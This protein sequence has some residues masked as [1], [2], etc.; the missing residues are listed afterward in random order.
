MNKEESS[1]F[2]PAAHGWSVVTDGGF[3]ELVGPIWQKEEEN[4]MIALA[5]TVEHKHHNRRGVLQGGMIATLLDRTIGTNVFKA[6]GGKP[7]A[8]LQL[9]IHY[10][11]GIKI[12][13]F[14]EARAKIERRTRAV[15]FASAVASVGGEPVALGHGVWK[16][17][18]EK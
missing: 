13:S 6:N 18:G 9:D 15:T 14:V 10:L 2:D 17:L 12:G 3:I 1:A 11:K 4:G 16:I 7:Q 5:F 8:T